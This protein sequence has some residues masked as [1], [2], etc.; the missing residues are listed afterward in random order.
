M[1]PSASQ[2]NLHCGPGSLLVSAP[3]CGVYRSFQCNQLPLL[4]LSATLRATTHYRTKRAMFLQVF[5]RTLI[6]LRYAKERSHRSPQGVTA[7]KFEDQIEFG[8]YW[9][10]DWSQEC[11]EE[12]QERWEPE[13]SIVNFRKKSLRRLYACEANVR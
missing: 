7:I 3:E 11:F 13:R 1:I 6:P 12:G 2:V 8:A 10:R 5:E 4:S 9:S